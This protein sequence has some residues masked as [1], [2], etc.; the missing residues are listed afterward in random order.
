M[1]TAEAMPQLPQCAHLYVEEDNYLGTP[2]PHSVIPYSQMNGDS[3]AAMLMKS[4]PHHG[5]SSQMLHPW[6]SLDN[7]QVTLLPSLLF[8]ALFTAFLTSQ[9][10]ACEAPQL[11][12]LPES[13]IFP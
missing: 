9:E 8:P 4:P 5:D 3:K 11:Q 13:C 10:E 6:S 7:L 12:E 1:L 2:L